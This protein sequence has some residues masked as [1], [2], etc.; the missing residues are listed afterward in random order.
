[1]IILMANREKHSSFS[2]CVTSAVKRTIKKTTKFH[3]ARAALE[4]R[5]TSK[6]RGA[7]RA[8]QFKVTNSAVKGVL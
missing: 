1:M 8:R 5:P 6:H 2:F 7:A 3:G 4:G